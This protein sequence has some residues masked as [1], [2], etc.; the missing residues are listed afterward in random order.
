MKNND[1]NGLTPIQKLRLEKKK[2]KDL[3]TEDERRLSEDWDYL[4]NNIGTLT[5]N[6]L[7]QNAKHSLGSGISP[8]AKSSSTEEKGGYNILNILSSSLPLIWEIAQP[9]LF[10]YMI[11]KI[12]SLFTSKKKKK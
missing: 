6:S 11:K 9:I 2:L 1:V 8:F 5:L 3:Y 4:T 10:S 7:F 12:K